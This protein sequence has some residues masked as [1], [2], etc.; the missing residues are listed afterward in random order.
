MMN[1][2]SIFGFHM[3]TRLENL[4]IGQEK[5]VVNT[6][7]AHS[8]QVTK[9]DSQFK[10][11][12]QHSDMLFPDGIGVVLAARLLKR[13]KIKRITGSDI[14]LHLL[15]QLNRKKGRV[16]YL[17]ASESTLRRIKSRLKKEYPGVSVKTYSPPFKDTFTPA[18]NARMTEAVNAFRPDV[19]FV[20]MTAPKQEKWSYVQSRSLDAGIIASIGAVFDFYAGT[21]QR[22]AKIWQ[23]LGLEWLVRLVREPRRL[24]HRYLVSTPQILFDI[25]KVKTGLMPGPEYAGLTGIPVIRKKQMH[26]FSRQESL[27]DDTGGEEEG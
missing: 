21:V 15:R 8:Y 26:T 12:L 25:V 22:P 4:N 14:H 7:N 23:D 17:G 9:K 6:L 13:K 27:V 16:F 24:W 19:L 2:L 10:K 18:E 3:E 11:A 20:G 1:Y 5:L